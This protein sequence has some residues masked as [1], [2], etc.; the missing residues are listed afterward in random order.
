MYQ[1]V[2]SAVYCQV[3]AGTYYYHSRPPTTPETTLS[4]Q[5]LTRLLLNVEVMEGSP[6][7]P[8]TSPV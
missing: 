6:I 2:P 5:Q 1:V 4:S 8:V 7:Q 3:I